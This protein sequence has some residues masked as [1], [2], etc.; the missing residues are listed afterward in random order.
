M[1]IKLITDSASDIDVE[2]IKKYDIEVLSSLVCFGE[3]MYYDRE[4]IN[5]KQ[6]FE[7][8]NEKDQIPTTA[9]I[10]PTRYVESINKFIDD[11]DYVVVLT[12][13][14]GYSGSYNSALIAKDMVG[15]DKVYV[16][17]SDSI[18]AGYG[19]IV[20]SIAKRISEAKNIDEVLEYAK[21]A[22]E[23]QETI[24]VVSTLE[25]LKKGGRITGTQAFLGSLLNIKVIIELK[26]KVYP[27]EKIRGMKKA[28]KYIL[29]KV[30]EANLD[31]ENDDIVLTSCL[32]DEEL[33]DVKNKLI[34]MGAKNITVMEM[35]ATVGTHAGPGAVGVCY[36]K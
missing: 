23:N 22:V 24:A 6:L 5:L 36:I 31:L 32:A 15:S 4:E 2:S 1:K 30:E 13:G 28:I 3:E 34:E 9:Q 19:T 16:I 26:E 10:I 25:Y 14:T 27:I 35:G 11:Y 33:F 20:L 17:D 12:M 21:Y 29:N 18:A 8:I 7:K